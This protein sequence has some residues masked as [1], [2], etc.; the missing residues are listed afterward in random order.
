[1]NESLSIYL[2][3][4]STAPITS[5]PSSKHKSSFIVLSKQRMARL[6]IFRW[7]RKRIS[8]LCRCSWSNRIKIEMLKW[9]DKKASTMDS[10]TERESFWWC[11]R[12]TDASPFV[13]INYAVPASLRDVNHS[14]VEVNDLL[15]VSLGEWVTWYGDFIVGDDAS[16]LMIVLMLL[17]KLNFYSL[18]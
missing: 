15:Q 16:T 10:K 2:L 5:Q 17:Y 6:K 4:F 3:N 7:T 1:M 13:G 18:T 12:L 14:T 9:D 11:F 8:A